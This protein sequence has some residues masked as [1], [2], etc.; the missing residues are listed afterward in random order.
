MAHLLHACE[1]V[2]DVL[3]FIVRQGVQ[4]RRRS[5][6]RMKAGTKP[7]CPKCPCHIFGILPRKA[8]H[9][10]FAVILESV[11][12]PASQSAKLRPSALRASCVENRI[13]GRLLRSKEIGKIV[14]VAFVQG[15]GVRNHSGVCAALR[16]VRP[17]LRSEIASWLT[18]QN[19]RRCFPFLCNVAEE[20]QLRFLLSSQRI[21]IG[22]GWEKRRNTKNECDLS[23]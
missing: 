4:F 5:A 8:G 15:R 21:G 2:G 17:D 6:R 23:H 22:Y 1:A 7:D 18:F 16:L 20:A 13:R 14:N 11:A 9:F 10:T 19:R 12:R 3:Y